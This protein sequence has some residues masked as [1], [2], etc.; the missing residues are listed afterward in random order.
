MSA[1]ADR[2]RSAK[3]RAPQRR[4]SNFFMDINQLA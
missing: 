1:A 2:R 3:L 4:T